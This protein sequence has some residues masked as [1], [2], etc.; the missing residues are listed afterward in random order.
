MKEPLL[1]RIISELRKKHTI[2]GESLID[3]GRN[4]KDALDDFNAAAFNYVP[5]L[6]DE[7]EKRIKGEGL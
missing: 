4:Q 3:G 1:N 5:F 6:I 2:A 7:L